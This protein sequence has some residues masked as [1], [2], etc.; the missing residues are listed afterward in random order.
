MFDAMLLDQ[1]PGTLG[2]DKFLDIANAAG[3]GGHT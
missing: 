1:G 3:P 2:S